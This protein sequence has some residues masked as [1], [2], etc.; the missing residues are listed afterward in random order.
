VHHDD[1]ADALRD[2]GY[3]VRAHPWA[4]RGGDDVSVMVG[5]N[6]MAHLYLDLA[7]RTRPWWS[8]LAATR[9]PLVTWL[10]ARPSVDLVLL[11]HDPT[12]CAVRSRDGTALVWRDAAGRHH[13]RRET[14]DPLRLGA[15]TPAPGLEADETY[16]ATIDGAYPDALVQII[17]LAG[18]PRAGDVILSATPSWD[19]R[20]RY[21]PVP[22][23]SSH[24]ALHRE[25]MRVPFLTSH[26]IRGTP[27]RTV[28][29]FP[30]A[31]ARLGRSVPNAGPGRSF[32]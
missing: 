16:D 5:G 2:A 17:A 13:Y 20:E 24:G 4:W 21:E 6:G 8:A 31:L 12:R 10:L 29:V 30:S 27:R 15:D 32:L 26:P 3:G 18:A 23:R 25:H 28:D 1:L 7:R 22:H 11:P 14:G 9:E 19:F